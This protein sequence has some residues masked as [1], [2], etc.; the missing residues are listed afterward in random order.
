MVGCCSLFRIRLIPVINKPL[1]NQKN[2]IYCDIPLLLR[3]NWRIW[4]RDWLIR[5]S[6]IFLYDLGWGSP[7]LRC[8]T[9]YTVDFLW[10]GNW[11]WMNTIITKETISP[12]NNH[13]V[14]SKT[15]AKKSSTVGLFDS[16]SAFLFMQTPLSIIVCILGLQS[17]SL[18]N[19]RKFFHLHVFSLSY[20]NKATDNL[21]SVAGRV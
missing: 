12:G 4:E 11:V 7:G 20:G 21:I 5:D 18:G 17:C 6:S 2:F 16:D 3:R 10:F 15:K 13:I 19:A 1:E 9:H 8:K 14:L